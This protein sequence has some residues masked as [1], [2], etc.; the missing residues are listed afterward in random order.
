MD[1]QKELSM[2]RASA[3]TV[4]RV[5]TDTYS[6]VRAVSGLKQQSPG[7]LLAQAWEEYVENHR[8]ELEET[9]DTVSHL[10]REGDSEGLVAFMQQG[11]KE[12]AQRMMRAAG[13][14]D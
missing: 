3:S 12:R 5:P 6:H 10:I 11:S 13:L 7:S 14:K 2:G 4:V 1:K 8:D 9:F